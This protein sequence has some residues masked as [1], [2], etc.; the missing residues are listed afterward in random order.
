[1]QHVLVRHNAFFAAQQEYCGQGAPGFSKR[2]VE[3]CARRHPA[4]EDQAPAFVILCVEM[5]TNSTE[6]EGLEPE[7]LKLWGL[8]YS[9]DSPCRCR[10][11]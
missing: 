11:P 9:A 7:R 8:Y 3:E 6:R 4:R 10:R 5:D 1:M 2:H